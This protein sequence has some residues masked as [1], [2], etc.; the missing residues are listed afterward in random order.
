MAL[1]LPHPRE[2]LGDGRGDG[3]AANP[4]QLGD[5]FL[6]LIEIEVRDHD[7]ALARTQHAQ[8]LPDA[9]TIQQRID[10]IALAHEAPG[11]LQRQRAV[12]SRP[13]SLSHGNSKQPSG[14]VGVV[15]RR[16]I[17]ARQKLSQ[18]QLARAAGVSR[19]TISS[20]ETGQ[21]CPS[22]LLAFRLAGVLAVRV[23]DLFWIEGEG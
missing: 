12:S 18:E 7:R 6:G 8:Q 22:A 11:V 13:A 3:A 19:Q 16:A 21:Y 9:E 20:I 10:L 5:L 15:K 2:R 14:H 17:E 4:Q 1:S 23:D